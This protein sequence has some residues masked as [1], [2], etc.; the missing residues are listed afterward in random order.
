MIKRLICK[1]ESLVLFYASG[2]RD[3]RVFDH[4]FRFDIDRRPNRHIAFGHGEHFCMGAHLARR[5]QRAIVE[6]LARRVEDWEVIGDPEWIKASFVVGL[7]RLPV[8]YRI[9]KR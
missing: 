8:R 1:G 2:N 7:K 6:E 4:P 3:D 5:S 9:A